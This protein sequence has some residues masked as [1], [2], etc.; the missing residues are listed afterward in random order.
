[1]TNKTYYPSIDSK[2]VKGRFFDKEVLL[3]AQ[4]KE[5]D[6]EIYKTVPYVEIVITGMNDCFIA[7]SQE[8]HIERF[9]DAWRVYQGQAAGNVVGKPIE[10][11]EGIGEHLSYKLRSRSICTIEDLAVADSHQI[12]RIGFGLGDL[13]KKAQELT[14][15]N[16]NSNPEMDAMKKELEELKALLVAQ[17]EP[18]KRGRKP[19]DTNS[20]E[21]VVVSTDE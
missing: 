12:S 14:G 6:K 21:N 5:A 4:S 11:L 16:P 15:L 9:P 1:M 7:P 2:N 18:K 8:K 10:E 19:K 17:A 20:D 3:I 13:Q